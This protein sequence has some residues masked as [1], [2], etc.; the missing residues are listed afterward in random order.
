MSDWSF[1]TNHARVLLAIANDPGIRL[2][3]IAS[4]VGISERR[5][6]GIV[7]DLAEA[8]YLARQRQGRRNRYEI[9]SHLPLRDAL[10]D[11]RTVG[12]ILALLVDA[13]STTID[14]DTP[15]GDR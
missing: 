2:R 15:S 14:P 4:A 3:E 11:Q 7:T 6:H 13:R 12:E 10:T 8:G 9:Q 1:F 5:A